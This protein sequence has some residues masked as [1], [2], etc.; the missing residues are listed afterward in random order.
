MLSLDRYAED[1]LGA[2]ERRALRRTLADTAREETP[3]VTR[4][5]RRL[6]SFSC[7]DY[8]GLSRHPAVKAAAIAAVEQ[9]GRAHV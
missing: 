2:L 4:G 7:N 8:L 6:L 3:F 1:K 5:G 9:I